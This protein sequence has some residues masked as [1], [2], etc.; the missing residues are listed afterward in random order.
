MAL[1]ACAPTPAPD[2]TPT[3][4]FASEEEAFAAAEAT[5]R[6]YIDAANQSWKEHDRG[7]TAAYLTGEALEEEIATQRELA[8]RGIVVV[9]ELR[10]VSFS[11][12]E[13]DEREQ[14]VTAR[15]C[16]DVTSSRLFNS[17]GTDITP[18]DRDPLVGLHLTFAPVGDGLA[19]AATEPSGEAC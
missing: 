17:A 2:P 18:G 4:L 6:A 9:G 19:V 1:G 10:V 12:A 5:Y 7:K 16:I 3:P 11:G 14:T 13:S 15:A 8:S